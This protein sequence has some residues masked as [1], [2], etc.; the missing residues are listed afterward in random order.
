MTSGVV[1]ERSGNAG[2]PP[3][4]ETRVSLLLENDSRGPVEVAR[5]KAHTRHPFGG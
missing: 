4:T 3:E 5:L 2:F 1:F